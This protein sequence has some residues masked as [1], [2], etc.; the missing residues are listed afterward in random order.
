MALDT[1]PSYL[2]RGCYV[3]RLH[4]DADPST[5]RLC[6]RLEHVASGAASSFADADELLAA[7][8]RL[9]ALPDPNVSQDLSP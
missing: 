1:Q 9:A 6:G 2:S 7:L 3:L 4:R 5:G 8:R